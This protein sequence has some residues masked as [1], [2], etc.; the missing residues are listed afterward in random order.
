LF[1]DAYGSSLI[2][3]KGNQVKAFDISKHFKLLDDIEIKDEELKNKVIYF[4]IKYK[5]VYFVPLELPNE[6]IFGFLL[7]SVHS[8][9]FCNFKLDGKEFI[10]MMY[11]LGDFQDYKFNDQIILVEGIKECQTFKLFYP[12]VIA[13]LTSQPS[14]KL[15]QYLQNITN[16]LILV[17]DNDEVGRSLKYMKK[18]NNYNK[19]YCQIS[20]DFG[21]YWSSQ[22]DKYLIE[23]KMILKKEGLII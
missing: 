6:E 11:G 4:L 10:P 7:K 18:Y 20:K 12:Y 5:D 2:F 16:R 17:P 1:S 14:K 8:K 19:Y 9:N 22:D 3:K 21:D 13:Y 15:F 23:A